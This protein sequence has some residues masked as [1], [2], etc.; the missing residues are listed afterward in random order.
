MIPS[1]TRI[2]KASCSHSILDRSVATETK[3]YNL[4]QPLQGDLV[5]RFHG[6]FLCSIPHQQRTVY[7]VLLEYIHGEDVRSLRRGGLCAEHKDAITEVALEIWVRARS[8]GVIH[9]D[10]NP[11]NFVLRSVA[12]EK[13][14]ECSD[15][16]Q[17]NVGGKGA[18]HC[19]TPNCPLHLSVGALDLRVVMIDL[20]DVAFREPD[21]PGDLDAREAQL[22]KNRPHTEGWMDDD[23]C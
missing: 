11:R 16:P 3:S 20:E 9:C 14:I 10:V 6:L 7:V 22:V 4:L 13:S 17:P 1:T 23:D 18:S 15:P 2:L 19:S 21:K 5:P 12:E 8:L